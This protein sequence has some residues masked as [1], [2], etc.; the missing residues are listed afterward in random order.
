VAFIV[1][2]EMAMIESLCTDD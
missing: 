2:C 1:L